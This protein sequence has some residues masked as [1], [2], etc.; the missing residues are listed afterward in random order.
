MVGIFVAVALLG[1]G[2]YLVANYYIKKYGTPPK[3][4]VFAEE[5]ST[6]F[7]A[8]QTR[9]PNPPKPSVT[10]NPKPGAAIAPGA[11]KAPTASPSPTPSEPP[12]GDLAKVVWPQGLLLRDQPGYESGQSGGVDFNT[13]VY[14]L[15]T[16]PDQVWQKVQV[17]GKSLQGWVKAG[18]LEKIDAN[19]PEVAAPNPAAPAP[20]APAPD[21]PAPEAPAPDAP[22]APE[23]PPEPPQ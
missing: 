18:N 10:P 11:P 15:E 5:Y 8:M 21:A 6:P 19:T 9:A 4:P 1:A 14:I 17:R 13:Q 20:D 22:T 12:K 16:S 23:P 2:G 3:K 7:A